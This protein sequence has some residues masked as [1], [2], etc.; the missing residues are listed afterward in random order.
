MQIKA[1]LRWTAVLG[2]VLVV[3][4]TATA[5]VNAPPASDASGTAAPGSQGGPGAQN[6]LS[7]ED[8]AKM[9]LPELKRYGATLY[10]KIVANQA[11]LQRLYDGAVQTKNAIL[12]QELSVP[13]SACDKIAQDSKS[14]NDELQALQEQALGPVRAIDTAIGKVE[15]SNDGS[16]GKAKT[17]NLVFGQAANTQ[18][19]VVNAAISLVSALQLA[20]G[21]TAQLVINGQSFAVS[22]SGTGAGGGTTVNV[23]VSTDQPGNPDTSIPAGTVFT[24]TPGNNGQPP[25]VVSSIGNG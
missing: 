3:A 20:V 25:V 12:Q 7:F 11:T 1:T 17:G 18:S 8:L 16:R 22:V 5:Q 13:L 14:K 15:L 21:Q 6:S 24:I 4:D 9:S 23:T 2:F 10:A 19:A